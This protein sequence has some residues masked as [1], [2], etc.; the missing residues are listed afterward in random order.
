MAR[1]V[2]PA[3]LV[4]LPRLL[5]AVRAE[6]TRGGRV[7]F[8]NG[9][10]DLLHVGHVRM[11]EGAA[12]LGDRLIVGVNRDSS[13]R[14]LKGPDRPFVP[15][16][17]RAELVAGLE[18]VDWVVGF[19]EETPLG[20]IQAIRPHV[21]VKGGDWP[22]ERIVGRRL[23]LA[24]DGEVVLIPFHEGLSTSRLA[25]RIRSGR[26]VISGPPRAGPRTGPE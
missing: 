2:G 25:R 12:E 19:A 15:F 13:V 18:A 1:E 4:S 16:A 26:G 3:T 7:V 24:R 5:E 17:E 23:V 6:E 10:F 9:C 11:L 21:L 22:A 8:T 14:R 20:L